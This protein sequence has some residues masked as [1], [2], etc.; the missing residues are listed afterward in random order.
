MTYSKLGISTAV[1]I[2]LLALFLTACSTTSV[3]PVRKVTGLAR[4]DIIVVHNFAT[5]AAEIE[6]DRGLGPRIGRGLSASSQTQEEIQVGQAVAR[7]L[8]TTLV[9]ELNDAGIP[10]VLAGPGV[11]MTDRTA[12][13]K[14]IFTT[15]DEGSRTAR[16]AIGFGMGRSKVRTRGLVYQGT[17]SNE[18]LLGEFQ[19]VAK[20]SMKPGMGPAG[21]AGATL[22]VS[23][24]T[25]VVSE[26][27]FTA[28][29]KDAKATAKKI[30]K[31]IKQ[32]YQQHGW[33]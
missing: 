1:A 19:T 20:S 14:G 24:G 9:K 22:A 4:P 12:S 2:P 18:R 23:A 33:L 7:A 27:F 25:A 31:R 6:L 3:E 11:R 17:L 16:A 28:V 21:A 30:A 26:K 13:L 32:Y 15:V 8:S 5:S 10:A 29:E